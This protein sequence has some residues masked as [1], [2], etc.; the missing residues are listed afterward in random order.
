MGEGSSRGCGDNHVAGGRMVG[1]HLGCRLCSV[2]SH[3]DG[4]PP[5]API[6]LSLAEAQANPS[7]CHRA[8]DRLPK[9]WPGD[10]DAVVEIKLAAAIRTRIDVETKRPLRYLR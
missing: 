7:R 4:L 1:D 8:A 3:A 6:A 2:N 10:A 9:A 5:R